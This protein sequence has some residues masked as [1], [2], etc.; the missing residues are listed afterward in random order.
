[1]AEDIEMIN[2]LNASAA[3]ISFEEENK[4]NVHRAEMHLDDSI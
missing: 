3:S 4:K 1:V 2:L